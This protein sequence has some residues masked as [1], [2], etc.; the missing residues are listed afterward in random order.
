MDTLETRVRNTVTG[1][2]VHGISYARARALGR[3]ALPILARMLRDNH[4][5]KYWHNVAHSIGA[6]GDTSYFDTLYTFIWTRF[7]GPIDE[8]TVEAVHSAQGSLA[9]MA[10]ISPRALDYLIASTSPSAWTSLP[11]SARGWPSEY[12]ASILAK[13]S[14][15]AVA[16]TDSDRARSA[17]DAIPVPT[18]SDSTFVRELRHIRAYVEKYGSAAAFEDLRAR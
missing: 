17:I 14:L 5:R 18:D 13:S 3:P 4:Y 6:I 7:Q 12:R 8:Y 9:P 1:K 11:W 10:S 16:Y 2:F 15:I